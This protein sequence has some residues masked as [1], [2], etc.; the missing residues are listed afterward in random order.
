MQP[1]LNIA[2]NAARNASKVIIRSIGRLDAK[3]ITEK[4]Q[5]DFVTEVDLMAEKEIITTLRKA[6]PD[7]TRF[8]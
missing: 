8:L 7:P 2:I 1:I 4:K 5:N 3:Q 6:Y